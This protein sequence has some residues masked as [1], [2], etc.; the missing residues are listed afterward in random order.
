MLLATGI[1]NGPPIMSE[2]VEGPPQSDRLRRVILAPFA[3]REVGQIVIVLL[4]ASSVFIGST[5]LA[6]KFEWATYIPFGFVACG[7]A[8]WLILAAV[9]GSPSAIMLYFGILAFVTNSMFRSR[10]AGEITTDWQSVLKFLIWLGAGAIGF[11]HM[12]PLRQVLTRPA[13]VCVIAY[14]VIALASSIYSPIPGYSFGCALALVCLFA[15]AFSL[16]RF[17]TEAQFL[18]TILIALTIFNIGGWF[19]YLFVPDLGLSQAEWQTNLSLGPR[20]AGLAGQGTNLGAVCATAVAAAFVLWYIGRAGTLL[21]LVLGLFAFATLLMS[22]AR[23]SEIA[24]ALGICLI[25]ASRSAWL[26]TGAALAGSLVL[27]LLQIYPDIISVIA[28]E[29]SRTGD[30]SELYTFTGRIQIWDFSWKEIKTSPILGFGYNSS[31]VVLGRYSG[32]ENN[33]M[34]DTAHNLIL[35]NLLSVGFLGVIPLVLAIVILVYKALIRPNPTVTFTLV[36]V[37]VSSVTD[38]EVIG[39]TPTLL[40]LLFFVV[41]AWPER[42]ALTQPQNARTTQGITAARPG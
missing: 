40:T 24:M 37:C 35:Q 21:S 36:M 23:T 25:L 32:F 2:N 26:M 5:I 39:T 13:C 9:Y 41:V 29:F 10:G 15:F 1:A 38:S 28:N 11:A 8:A 6:E 4:L 7:L 27:L 14:L 3:P 16:T 30:P 22:D 20:M 17:I 33:L 31:K 18:W 34:V 12:P 19:A 42:A